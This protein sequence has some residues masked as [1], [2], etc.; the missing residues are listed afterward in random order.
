MTHFLQRS[1][2]ILL[3]TSAL[4]TVA[5][6]ADTDGLRPRYLPGD[7]LAWAQPAVL[8]SAENP[9]RLLLAAHRRHHKAAPAGPPATYEVKKGD[10]LEKIAK[11]LGTS[12]DELKAANG[13]KK[14]TIQP[15]DTLKN[16][17]AKPE[18]K[19]K[20]G[21]HGKAAAEEAPPE[22]TT[23]K[24]R[25]G[26]T[27]FAVAQK[28][29]TS[30][31][32]LR[33]ANGLSRKAGIH[34][35]Q[36]LTLPSDGKAARADETPSPRAGRNR[37]AAEAAPEDAGA[38]AGAAGHLTTVGAP[39][40]SY[41]VRRGD[42]LEKAARKLGMSVAELK[43]ENHLKGS[44]VHRGQVLKGPS[45]SA[46]AYVTASG[47]T[48]AGV[49]QRFGVSVA[50]LRAANGLSRHAAV[51][52]GHKLRLP[53]GYRDHGAA[54]TPSR[55]ETPAPR[56]Q[57][58]RYT[59]PPYIPPSQDDN[60]PVRTQ[61]DESLPSRPQPYTG[62]ATP[63]PGSSGGSGAPAA[64]P[65]STPPP[66]DAQI[67]QMG[68]G[69]FDWPIRGDLLS[70]FGSKPTGQRNDGLNIQAA[71]GQPVRAAADGDVVY[72]GDQVPGFGNLVLIKHADGWVTAYGHLSH[73]D[74]KMQQKVTQGQ[75]IGSVGSTGGV[76]EPQ[77]HFEVRYAP[78]PLERARPIDPK[79]VLPR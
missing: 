44:A 6:S 10:T 24:V 46:K 61:P 59:P 36:T 41:K 3:A 56:Y 62:S 20:K 52:P 29:H 39:G 21:K 1:A 76:S 12:I 7:Q 22:P 9:A 17:K 55:S 57:P 14:S 2:L 67:S 37:H 42:T 13:L 71:A 49:A 51:R 11:T 19:A 26:D 70:D 54:T 69:K 25:H 40:A 79:L 5:T 28:F 74:V 27:L 47:D 34:S 30:V 35:G 68:R 73:V 23:Y 38:V 75:Q 18:A 50:Q 58:P 15:G 43:R 77:L 60:G 31:E 53:A 45:T 65:T 72:A 63:R 33:A 66:T 32:A 8:R 64:G 4:A 48:L 16:P 78:N